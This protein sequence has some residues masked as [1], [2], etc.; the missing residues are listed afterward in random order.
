M[1]IWRNQR[2]ERRRRLVASSKSGSRF[3]V[4]DA[5]R[6]H[7]AQVQEDQLRI[8]CPMYLE[9][10]AWRCVRVRA[11]ALSD[12]GHI[13]YI[14][15]TSASGGGRS[16]M[17]TTDYSG[18]IE[19]LPSL[20]KLA[21]CGASMLCALWSHYATYRYSHS[22]EPVAS[23]CGPAHFSSVDAPRSTAVNDDT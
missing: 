23:E 15:N 4:R 7:R 20:L 11:R 6:T 18:R 14:Y 2:P 1:E 19:D 10:G 3:A 21:P 22:D 17:R 5:R 9:L 13:Y 16:Q 8:Q 12:Q